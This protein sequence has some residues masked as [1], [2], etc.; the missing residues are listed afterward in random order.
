MS[1]S[2]PDDKAA[3]G[4]VEDGVGDGFAQDGVVGPFHVAGRCGDGY[5]LRRN[6]LASR[7]S[8]RVGGGKP[9][10]FIAAESAH[11]GGACHA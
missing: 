11:C 9:V 10:G 2:E 1:G 5:A 8:R 3:E 7:G 6:H 4:D